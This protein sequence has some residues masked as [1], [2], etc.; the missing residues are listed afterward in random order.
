M[1]LGLRVPLIVISPYAK[2][3]YVSHTQHEF[4]TVVKFIEEA[5]GLPSLGGADAR[6]DDLS[7]CFDFAL[8]PRAFTPIAAPRSAAFFLDQ[9]N[10]TVPPDND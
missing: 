5:Y 3:G 10:A 1:G 9:P 8:A 6:A 7:D 2:R 4:G